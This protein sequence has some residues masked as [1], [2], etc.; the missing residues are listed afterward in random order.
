MQNFVTEISP[1]VGQSFYCR[2]TATIGAIMGKNWAVYFTSI[3]QQVT[4]VS[5]IQQIQA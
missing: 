3:L 2:F 5:V 4:R 1:H